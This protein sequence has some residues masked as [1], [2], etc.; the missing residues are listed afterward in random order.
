[1]LD[2]RVIGV[3]R[4]GI[5]AGAGEDH[6]LQFIFALNL[7]RFLFNIEFKSNVVLAALHEK[8]ILEILF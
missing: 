5:V 3:F 2:L 8:K 4:S 7:T 6:Q 1:M